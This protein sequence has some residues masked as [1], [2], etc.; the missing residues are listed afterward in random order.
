[1]VFTEKKGLTTTGKADFTRYEENEE[2]KTACLLE[3]NLDIIKGCVNHPVC[4]YCYKKEISMKKPDIYNGYITGKNFRILDRELKEK[5]V[6]FLRIGKSV[7]CGDKRHIDILLKV[8]EVCGNNGT[9][10]VMPTKNLPYSKTNARMID[11]TGSIVFYSFGGNNFEGGACKNGCDNEYRERQ[12]RE[13][14]NHGTNIKIKLLSDFTVEPKEAASRGWYVERVLN[15]FPKE[16]IELLP[17]RINSKKFACLATGES[18]EM[19]KRRMI[20]R[21]EFFRFFE[22]DERTMQRYVTDK[23]DISTLI[24]GYFHKSYEYFLNKKQICGHFGTLETGMLYCDR[25]HSPEYE[26]VAVSL[27]RILDVKYG[28]R[29]TKNH[30][31]I[32]AE[33]SDKNYQ[34]KM[35]SVLKERYHQRTMD[36]LLKE[37]EKQG[38]RKQG[39]LKI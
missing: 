10:A 7:E 31:K 24:P 8:L 14:L 3:Y 6:K 13:Y 28:K 23:K 4:M 22:V 39:V 15:V 35:E 26:P 20:R 11:D 18:W 19:L 30:K 32:Y 36:D 27:N 5:N 33:R 1:M 38:E 34:I 17:L 16:I 9:K 29:K 37:A 21:E 25:C 2:I 12:A